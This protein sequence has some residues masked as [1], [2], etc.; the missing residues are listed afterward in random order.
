MAL[1]P[2]TCVFFLSYL[3]GNVESYFLCLYFSNKPTWVSEYVPECQKYP[4]G[5]ELYK[6]MTL[7]I[8]IQV[9][10]ILLD[11]NCYYYIFFWLIF[12]CYY[13]HFVIVTHYYYYLLLHS[14]KINFALLF[15]VK[16]WLLSLI[17][18]CQ[19]YWYH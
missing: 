7:A 15:Y 2:R 18:N 10:K 17:I 12:F 11:F 6:C 13:I 9:I 16:C 14:E 4:K 8:H 1:W 3:W 5:I 19:S